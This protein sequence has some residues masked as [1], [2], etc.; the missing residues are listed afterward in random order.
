MEFERE[1]NGT[2]RGRNFIKCSTVK[3]KIPKAPN[4]L[5]NN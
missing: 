4:D 3:Q 1:Q 5:N 2:E